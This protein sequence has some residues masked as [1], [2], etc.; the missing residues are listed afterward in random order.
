MEKETQTKS[1]WLVCGLCAIAASTMIVEIVLTKFVGYKVY[2]HFI[3]LI[4]S[5]VILSFGMAGAYLYLAR[6]LSHNSEPE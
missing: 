1:F 5:T 4:I 3:H 2:H 6:S